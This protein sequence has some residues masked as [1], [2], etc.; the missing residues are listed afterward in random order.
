MLLMFIFASAIIYLIACMNW[1]R[2]ERA[3]NLEKATLRAKD[4]SALSLM[5]VV[6]FFQQ[7][8]VV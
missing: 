3:E 7:F 8:R 1:I 5:F 4:N 6:R 2:G